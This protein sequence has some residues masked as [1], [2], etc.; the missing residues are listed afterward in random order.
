MKVLLVGVGGVGEAIA[1]IA[2]PRQWVEQ[3]VLADYNQERAR[4][5]QAKLGDP[6]R[7]PVEFVD[8]G[9]QELIENLAKKYKVDLVMN[10][11]DPSFNIPIFEAAYEVGCN[12]MDMAMTL[13][14]PHPA[15]SFQEVRR[16]TGGLPVRTRQSVGGKRY[17]VFGG[18]WSGTRHG[19]CLCPL[20]SGSPLR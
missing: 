17:P 18:T 12:Y 1:R 2:E 4:E 10:A 5:V 14:A 16:K 19:R 13:S 11:C 7:F 15:G 8:A 9:K 3:L 6:K 20:C